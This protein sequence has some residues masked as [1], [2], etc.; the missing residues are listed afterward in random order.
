[1]KPT[2]LQLGASR[3]E[4]LEPTIR[5]QFARPEWIHLGDSLPSER[6]IDKGV[7]Y[8]FRHY[9]IS[10]IV[11]RVLLKLE[12]RDANA[13]AAGVDLESLYART[14]FEPY[15]YRRGERLP[16]PDRMFTYIFSEHFFEH[17]F[18]DEAVDLLRECQR[19]MTEGG[20]NSYL[21]ARCRSSHVCAAGTRGLSRS[22][23]V[24]QS[25]EQAQ[26]SLECL[27]TV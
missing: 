15:H 20:G 11:R 26:D 9:S 4:Y 7:V 6:L 13:K 10:Y 3:L 16:F 27:R 2:R 1:M 8:I 17:L 14:N 19:V 23:H 5:D 24:V 21:C 22:K 12:R 25:S 18:L